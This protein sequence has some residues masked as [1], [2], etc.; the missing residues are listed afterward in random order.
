MVAKQNKLK[1]IGT[2]NKVFEGD[3]TNWDAMSNG[4]KN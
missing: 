1:Y 3:T 2:M 4:H